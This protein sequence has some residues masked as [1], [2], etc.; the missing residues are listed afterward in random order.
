MAQALDLIQ[1]ALR[2]I[3]AL[4]AGETADSDQANDALLLLNEMLAS[5]SNSRLLI[6][7][8]TEM[9]FSLTSNVKDYTIGPGGTAATTFTGSIAGFVLTV[10]STAMNAVTIG[11]TLTGTG[12][13]SGTK[14]T[15]FLTGAGGAGTY[16]VDTSQ[17]AASTTITGAFHRP[18]SI[19]SGFVR[20]AT[21]DYPLAILNIEDYERIG[22]KSLNGPWPRAVYYQPSYPVGNLTFWPLPSSGEVHLI[23]DT[24]LQRFTTLS[25]TVSLP[26]GYHLAIRYNLAELMMPEYGRSAHDTA[27][28]VSRFAAEGRALIKR[29][30][31]RPQQSMTFDP[32]LLTNQRGDAGFV[33]NG[34]FR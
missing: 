14:V 18:L 3:G 10:T 4:E 13:T 7:Y 15:A 16:T 25:D 31:M 26:Q 1:G 24:L 20:V 6:H 29:T 33:L 23:G 30:N 9:V 34:G 32:V 21:I 17:T 8:E 5:W 19:R 27:Q 11:Q 12:V 2:T 22:L 28:L